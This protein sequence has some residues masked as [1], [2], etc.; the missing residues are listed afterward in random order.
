MPLNSKNSGAEDVGHSIRPSPSPQPSSIWEISSF[1]V[2]HFCLKYFPLQLEGRQMPQALPTGCDMPTVVLRQEFGTQRGRHSKASIL[3]L[4]VAVPASKRARTGPR[5]STSPGVMMG[6][7]SWGSF[8]WFGMSL[9]S[10]LCSPQMWV[11]AIL[12]TLRSGGA[13]TIPSNGK[14]LE[15]VSPKFRN[16]TDTYSLNQWRCSIG[17]LLRISLWHPENAS[18][19]WGCTAVL[20]SKSSPRGVCGTGQK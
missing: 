16:Q 20:V 18:P 4:Q 2:F 1:G 5:V 19:S 6:L 12:Q 3:S 17:W 15:L 13:L 8:V 11:L 14:Q 10:W 7:S 9:L